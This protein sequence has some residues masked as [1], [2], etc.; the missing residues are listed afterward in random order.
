MTQFIIVARLADVFKGAV[1]A[2]NVFLNPCPPRIDPFTADL[3][4]RRPSHETLFL[5]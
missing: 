2:V 3:N 4:A 5:Y 1:N